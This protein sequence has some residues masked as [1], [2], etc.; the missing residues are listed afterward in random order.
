MLQ[1]QT[2]LPELVEVA[3]L[4]DKAAL[5]K[6][7]KLILADQSVALFMGSVYAMFGKG[8]SS[9]FLEKVIE[10]K[11]EKRRTQPLAILTSFEE[12]VSWLDLTKIPPALHPLLLDPNGIIT[13][14]KYCMSRSLKLHLSWRRGAVRFRVSSSRLSEYPFDQTEKEG[15]GGSN[16]KNQL[17]SAPRVRS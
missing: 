9:S 10:V 7:A 13:N 5:E 1:L 14:D 17:E 12:L 3:S 15:Q 2:P 16:E 8:E 6:A 11:G 4:R